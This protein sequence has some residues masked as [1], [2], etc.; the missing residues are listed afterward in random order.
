MSL[1]LGDGFSYLAR[2]PL[3]ER[4]TFTTLQDMVD[5]SESSLYTG[6][7]SYNKE[8]NAFYTFNA[9][10]PVDA[11]LGKWRDFFSTGTVSFTAT[12]DMDLSSS[13]YGHLLITLSDGSVLDC[14]F[15]LG[16]NVATIEEYKPD[17]YYDENSLLFLG[18]RFGRTT[19]DYTTGSVT[20]TIKDLFESDPNIVIMR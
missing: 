13:T 20:T 16:G 8:T 10:N 12:V 19:A 6:I 2:K 1:K 7:I 5:F 15:I 11:T 17:T 3:D 9:D 18:D 14:G 4:L